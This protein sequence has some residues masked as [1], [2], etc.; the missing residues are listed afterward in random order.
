MLRTGNPKRRAV[1]AS[2][3]LAA[4]IALA[5]V[6][7]RGRDDRP[8]MPDG[9]CLHDAFALPPHARIAAVVGAYEAGDPARDPAIAGVRWLDRALRERGFVRAGSRYVRGDVT[10]DVV[11]PIAF[12]DIAGTSAAL[13]RASLEHDVVYYTGHSYD[14]ELAL[15]A[16][17]VL[18]L[19]T[20][21]SAQLYG[22]RASRRADPAVV[23]SE[24]SV[25][26]SIE[27]LV[28]LVDGEPLAALNATAADRAAKRSKWAAEHYGVL[29]RCP[30]R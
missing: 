26:G 6:T 3:G 11:G 27:S 12:D 18:V 10:I 21:W 22:E 9:I 14:G 25:A 5:V 17:G 24:R 30:T 7:L 2:C 28:E 20:C 23:N 15:P 8:A 1:D 4:A 13:E 19:D 29:A 16:R